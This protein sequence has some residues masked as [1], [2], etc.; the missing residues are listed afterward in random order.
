MQVNTSSH[1]DGQVYHQRRHGRPGPE[2]TFRRRLEERDRWRRVADPCQWNSRRQLKL[3][4][5][6]KL[7]RTS[8]V[9]PNQIELFT[10]YGCEGCTGFHHA[11]DTTSPRTTGIQEYWA[12]IIR[13]RAVSGVSSNGNGSGSGRGGLVQGN[14]QQ[15]ALESR[16]TRGPDKLVRCF[17]LYVPN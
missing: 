13:F 12:A 3:H 10:N 2:C 5:S 11:V 6:R 7:K 9:E 17:E 15:T 14:F 4:L 1:T 8:R 16:V